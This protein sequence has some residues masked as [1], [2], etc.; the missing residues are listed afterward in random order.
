M[1]KT[2]II[3]A[4]IISIALIPPMVATMVI[5]SRISREEEKRFEK[6]NV[7]RGVENG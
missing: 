4:C 3:T 1:I 6:A 2:I 7:K 5:S